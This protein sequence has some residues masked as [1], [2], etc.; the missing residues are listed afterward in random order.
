MFDADIHGLHPELVKVLGRLKYRTSYGQ[1]VLKHCLEVSYLAGLMASEIGA[2]VK[3]AKR[4]GLLHDIGKAIDHESEGTHVTIGVDLAK[5]YGEG[6][7]V[8]HCIEAHHGGVE[9]HSI[10]AILVQAADAISA[11]RPGARRESIEN[12]IKRL[13]DLENIANGFKGVEKCYAIQA[14]REIRVM[15]KPDEVSDDDALF[16]AKEIAK[17]IEESMQYPGQIKVN[18]I[19]ESR[20]VEYAK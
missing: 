4:G 13:T 14:G 1:N 15:V 11:A 5:K 17:K 6:E 8:I 19:R 10:E 18:V 7:P 2:D 3:I 20:S 16:L 9:F 12:Y